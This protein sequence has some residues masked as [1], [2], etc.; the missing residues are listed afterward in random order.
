MKEQTMAD[1][2]G[3]GPEPIAREDIPEDLTGVKWG[4]LR[5][6]ARALGLKA[7]QNL[8]RPELEFAVYTELGRDVV[9]PEPEP[10]LPEPDAAPTGAEGIAASMAEVQ[11]QAEDGPARPHFDVETLP[12]LTQGEAPPDP[13]PVEPPVV[14]APPPA[15]KPTPA[16]APPAAKRTGS[17]APVMY[18]AKAAK[19][20]I[21]VKLGKPGA[22]DQHGT[23]HEG[24]L[25]RVIAFGSDANPLYAFYAKEQWQVDAIEAS[26]KFT[27]GAC[28]RAD[29]EIAGAIAQKRAELAALEAMADGADSATIAQR[30]AAAKGE[31]QI[32]EGARTTRTGA[33]GESG[34]FQGMD[35]LLASNQDVP[36]ATG[37]LINLGA[38]LRDGLRHAEARGELTEE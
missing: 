13:K 31:V 23:W 26:I 17:T 32:V 29:R 15:P 9:P 1:E 36:T 5:A 8:K 38:A 7:I 37:G 35:A 27:R 21:C 28:W 16:P 14:A 20:R 24:V 18:H 11:A 30:M 19:L 6:T 34:D 4:V 25:P 10:V 12:D 3:N 22:Y 33:T 2:Q